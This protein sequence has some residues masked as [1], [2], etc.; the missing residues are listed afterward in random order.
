MIEK[1]NETILRFF[2]VS[3]DDDV[4]KVRLGA[5][6]ILSFFESDVREVANEQLD[7]LV[8]EGSL[9]RNFDFWE[10]NPEVN[11]ILLTNKRRIK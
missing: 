5:K 9:Y 1:I 6:E 8:L 11:D 2:V 7:R 10:D 3:N 4:F